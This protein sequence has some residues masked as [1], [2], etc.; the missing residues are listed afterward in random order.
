[1]LVTRGL[2]LCERVLRGLMGL[3]VV[4]R[5]GGCEGCSAYLDEELWFFGVFF[6]GLG[7]VGGV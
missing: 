1:M 6:F 4:W 3:A 5:R 2:L 7:V